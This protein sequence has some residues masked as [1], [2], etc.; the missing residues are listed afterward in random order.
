MLCEPCWCGRGGVH[1]ATSIGIGVRAGVRGGVVS[2]A[3]S[4]VFFVVGLVVAVV[5]GMKTSTIVAAAY[6]CWNYD[7]LCLCR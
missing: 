4:V 3:M 2:A 1:G 5:V 6:A 7:D